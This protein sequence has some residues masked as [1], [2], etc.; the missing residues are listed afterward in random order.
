MTEHGVAQRGVSEAKAGEKKGSG[1]VRE[2]MP[3]TERGGKTGG[4]DIGEGYW[5]KGKEKLAGDR[6]EKENLHV[7][8][9]G[10]FGE[11]TQ[12]KRGLERSRGAGKQPRWTEGGGEQRSCESGKGLFGT[13]RGG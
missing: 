13:E 9:R 3:A 8:K 2:I 11:G 5:R 10:K 7:S 12:K 6:E 4:W 1:I